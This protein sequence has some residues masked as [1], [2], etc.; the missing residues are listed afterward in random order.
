[1]STPFWWLLC[2]MRAACETGLRGQLSDSALGSNCNNAQG[3]G[4]GCSGSSRPGRDT[5]CHGESG[6]GEAGIG[7]Q[8]L[9]GACG[10]R[11]GRPGY[12]EEM[13]TWAP[14]VFTS[15]CHGEGH[16]RRLGRAER[17]SSIACFHLKSKI[18]PTERGGRVST[19]PTG[20][21]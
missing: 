20:T 15:G 6:R 11:T 3:W 8:H 2:F 9:D 18:P 7:I 21:L 13:L 10:Q 4:W 19:P 1:M 5:G 17:Q 14:P 16:A 12:V